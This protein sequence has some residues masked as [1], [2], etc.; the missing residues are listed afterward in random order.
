[1]NDTLTI[2]ADFIL[3]LTMKKSLSILFLFLISMQAIA[4]TRSDFSHACY[5]SQLQPA[6]QLF[7]QLKKEGQETQVLITQCLSESMVKIDWT[8][9]EWALK[10]GADPNL[11]NWSYYPGNPLG[12]AIYEEN[13]AAVRLLVSYGAKVDHPNCKLPNSFGRLGGYNNDLND[14]L[15]YLKSGHDEIMNLFFS[16][17]AF[18]DDSTQALM[19]TIRNNRQVALRLLRNGARLDDKYGQFHSLYYAT[20]YSDA[21]L[22]GALAKSGASVD[23]TVDS[24]LIHENCGFRVV[25]SPDVVK[26]SFLGF[27]VSK[28]NMAMLKE[29][30][31]NSSEDAL[32]TLFARDSKAGPTSAFFFMALNGGADY[33]R[34]LDKYIP[35]YLRH[36]YHSDQV[37]PTDQCEYADPLQV[38]AAND[39]VDE[40]LALLSIKQLW[41]KKD[42]TGVGCNDVNCD[43]GQILPGKYTALSLARKFNAIHVIPILE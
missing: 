13:A 16:L 12:S 17:P 30:L 11:G 42:S 38:A 31:K 7:E 9:V 35:D 22:V 18:S 19:A 14:C 40:V 21:E 23:F 1:M 36:F 6:S 20:K 43:P 39:R 28:K 10:Q 25:G 4:D 27:V 32:Y 33:I 37:W 24:E 41:E 26:Q 3:G 2:E 8:F 15:F 5:G 34:E 29:L